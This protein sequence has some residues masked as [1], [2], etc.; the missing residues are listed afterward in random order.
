V[1]RLQKFILIEIIEHVH[2]I[3]NMEHKFTLAEIRDIKLVYT[4]DVKQQILTTYIH[5]SVK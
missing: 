2:D 4:H 3:Y 5:A 1:F